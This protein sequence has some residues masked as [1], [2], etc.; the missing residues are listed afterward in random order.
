VADGGTVIN[1][2]ALS[3]DSCLVDTREFIFRGVSSRAF[4]SGVGSRKRRP[5]R[6]L[7]RRD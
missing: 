2:G 3:G 1:Y 7:L 5:P 6:S 4:G